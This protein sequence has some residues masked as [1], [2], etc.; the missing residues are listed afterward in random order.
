LTEADD[1]LRWFDDAIIYGLMYWLMM[2]DDGARKRN[3]I[4]DN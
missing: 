3:V 1:G 4:T 2:A